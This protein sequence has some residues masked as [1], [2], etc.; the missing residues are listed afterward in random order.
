MQEVLLYGFWNINIP[1]KDH[2]CVPVSEWALSGSITPQRTDWGH[3]TSSLLL[4]FKAEL[5]RTV[6]ACCTWYCFACKTVCIW[7][8]SWFQPEN[9]IWK[10]C[11]SAICYSFSKLFSKKCPI[12]DFETRFGVFIHHIC[13]VKEDE[14]QQKA[15][16]LVK[17]CCVW[18]VTGSGRCFINPQVLFDSLLVL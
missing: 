2:Y 14:I 13:H 6:L 18:A 1:V 15:A 4:Q 9:T 11:F 17:F 8:E 7:S 12:A 3:N 5:K 10:Y 16:P